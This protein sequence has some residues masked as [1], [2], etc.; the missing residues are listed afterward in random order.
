MS[1]AGIDETSRAS[2]RGCRSA[3][4]A[5]GHRSDPAKRAP[6]GRA[7]QRAVPLPRRSDR[8]TR[9][10]RWRPRP[11]ILRGI[12]ERRGHGRCRFDAGTRAAGERLSA[13]CGP[14]ATPV[15]PRSSTRSSPGEHVRRRLPSCSAWA[16]APRSRRPAR[17]RHGRSERQTGL[18]MLRLVERSAG[19]RDRAVSRVGLARSADGRGCGSR[20]GLDRTVTWKR[21][22][23]SCRE[24]R[25]WGRALCEDSQLGAVIAGSPAN[26]G[27][28]NSIAPQRP[29]GR[30]APAS[31]TQFAAA[32]ASCPGWTPHREKKGTRGRGARVGPSCRHP[33]SSRS[34]LAAHG[35]DRGTCSGAHEHA[36]GSAGSDP[37]HSVSTSPLGTTSTG[38]PD[39]RGAPPA[40]PRIH[41]RGHRATGP[42][43]SRRGA[44]AHRPDSCSGARVIQRS[45]K[46][47]SSRH[48][49]SRTSRAG[50]G[51]GP[52]APLGELSRRLKPG[53]SA[54]GLESAARASSA[55]EARLVA[56]RKRAA[57]RA[58]PAHPRARRSR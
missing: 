35:R 38:R 51:A 49:D 27:R 22:G 42:G 55:R 5:S 12:R 25:E 56:R 52:G 14:V 18:G 37:R 40:V 32:R 2:G 58:R 44:P 31:V 16:C 54:R 20:L 23:G 45:G 50:G 6:C 30:S 11:A 15:A 47:E 41:G 8:S 33:P 53:R 24:T 57:L 7:D 3:R 43:R 4:G 17:R 19:E 29:S 34:Y 46:R 10:A 1:G 28:A 26:D 48:E 9:G 21:T 36:R 13:G 39:R